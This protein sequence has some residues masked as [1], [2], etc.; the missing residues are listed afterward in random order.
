MT[1]PVLTPL[2]VPGRLVVDPTDLGVAFPYGGN[3]LGLALA[4]TLGRPER[5]SPSFRAE[6]LGGDAYDALYLGEDWFASATLAQWDATTMGA[7]G[8]ETAAGSG[9]LPRSPYPATTA[10]PPQLLSARSSK[11]LFVPEHV[12]QGGTDTDEEA[13]AWILYRAAPAIEEPIQF[14][15]FASAFLFLA[16]EG[17]PD[18]SGRVGDLGAFGD[19]SL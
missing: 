14:T 19:L 16:W 7:A 8:W 1:S 13:L 10:K 12:V 4:I 17:L 5:R 2:R 15:G 9:T 6:E 18:D 3:E 11:L